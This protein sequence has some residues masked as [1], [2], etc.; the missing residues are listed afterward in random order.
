M[1]PEVRSN[2][3]PETDLEGL[4]RLCVQKKYS[5]FTLDTSL[6]GLETEI[7]CRVVDITNTQHTTTL[8]MI[9]SKSSEYKALFKHQ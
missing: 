9:I 8:S 6:K 4:Q 5:F 3:S 1:A 2:A 7:P